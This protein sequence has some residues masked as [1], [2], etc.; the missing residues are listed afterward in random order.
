MI[1][2]AYACRTTIKSR[3][4]GRNADRNYQQY[5]GISLAPRAPDTATCD[6]LI[7]K[8]KREIDDNPTLSDTEKDKEKKVYHT[9]PQAKTY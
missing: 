5:A 2:D 1:C 7:A 8:K 6:A 9:H 3:L 4:F